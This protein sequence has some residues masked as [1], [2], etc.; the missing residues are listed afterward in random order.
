MF[1]KLK[2]FPTLCFFK[3]LSKNKGLEIQ[4]TL[5]WDFADWFEISLKTR[6]KCDHAGTIFT[7]SLLRFIFFHIQYYDFRHWDD[8]NDK[9]YVYD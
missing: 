8:D 3:A 7:I 5:Q 2:G 9:F 1:K 4:L 6:T